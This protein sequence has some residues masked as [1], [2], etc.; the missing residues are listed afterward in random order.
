MSMTRSYGQGARR[1]QVPA[2]LSQPGGVWNAAS[3]NVVIL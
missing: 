3:L 2:I 1:N